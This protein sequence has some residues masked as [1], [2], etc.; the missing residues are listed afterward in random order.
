M[1]FLLW[2]VTSESVR[3]ERRQKFQLSE[4]QCDADGV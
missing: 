2:I 1:K 4:S 3:L